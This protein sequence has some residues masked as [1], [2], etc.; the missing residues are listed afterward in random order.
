MQEL[1]PIRIFNEEGLLLKGKSFRF[2]GPEFTFLTFL[3]SVTQGYVAKYSCIYFEIT[4]SFI[5]GDII[6]FFIVEASAT[7][8][9]IQSVRL[10]VQSSELS[11][12]TPLPASEYCSP[13]PLGSKG[14]DTLTFS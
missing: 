3:R 13:P 2:Y 9:S 8:Q 12:P 7:A 5:D 14:G 4:K 1:R 6:P 10:S 11:L